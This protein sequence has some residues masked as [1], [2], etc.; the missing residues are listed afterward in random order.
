VKKPTGLIEYLLRQANRKHDLQNCKETFPKEDDNLTRFITRLARSFSC[1]LKEKQFITLCNVSVPLTQSISIGAWMAGHPVAYINPAL[2]KIQLKNVLTKLGTSLN[3]GR[4]DCLSLQ[5]YQKD[6][7]FP[8]PDEDGSNNLFDRLQPPKSEDP[9][10]SYDWQDDECAVVAFTSG[11]T[12]MPKGVCHSLG[13]LIRSTELFIRHY[14]IEPNDRILTLAPS[15]SVSGFR[16]LVL[17]PLLSGCH[18]VKLPDE[19]QLGNVLDIFSSEKPT[20][21]DCGPTFIRQI[22]ML[23]DKLDDELSSIRVFLSSGSKLDN[24]SRVRLWEKRGIP[25]LDGY[26]MTE[27]GGLVVAENIENYNPES[28]SIGK[29]CSGVTVELTEVDGVSDQELGSGQIRIYSQNLFLGYLGE[30]LAR[31]RY[32]ETGDLAVQDEAGNISI[33][34]RLDHGVKATSG[35]WLFP[36]AVEQLLVNR[37]DVDDAHVRSEYDQYDRGVLRAKVV[38]VNPEIV[39][40]GWIANLNQD[41]KD[42]LGTDYKASEI[43]IASTIP[44]TALGKVIKGSC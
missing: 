35:F 30:P 24:R 5:E 12:G 23:A 44:R 27:T 7:L 34:G 9:F 16:K 3:I 31:K 19:P 1:T 22:A 25:V 6:W 39:D 26:G 29:V 18:L 20:V 21:F 2:T 33:I 13:N 28:T 10:V 38:P 36:Q 14:S 40:D 32:L 43:E 37:A 8:D 11:T 42:Q 41:I 17:V 15:Y 4:P